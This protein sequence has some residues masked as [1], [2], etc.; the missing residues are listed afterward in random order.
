MTA[1]S[2]IVQTFLDYYS[3]TRKP[4]GIME[5][6]FASL[7]KHGY[8]DLIVLARHDIIFLAPSLISPLFDPFWGTGF[9]LG[10]EHGMTFELAQ[11]LRR[12]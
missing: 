6:T 7:T 8:I 4:L 11:T 9:H 3:K 12:T 2:K 10:G 1:H 5:L